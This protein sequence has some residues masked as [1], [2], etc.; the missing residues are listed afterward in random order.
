MSLEIT[1]NGVGIHSGK[2]THINIR[3]H[4]HGV[5]FKVDSAQIP[6]LIQHV[7]DTQRATTISSGDNS[8]RTIEH[9]CSAIYGLN[10]SG[11][12]ITVVG[13]EIPILDGSAMP[14]IEA[15]A[16]TLTKECQSKPLVI[17]RTITHRN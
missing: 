9:L 17:D 2:P 8:L 5:L 15:L 1:I 7:K 3:P 12:E 13:G 4:E 11:A 6:A 16:D 14:F 10:L